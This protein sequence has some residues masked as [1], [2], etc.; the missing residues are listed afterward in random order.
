MTIIVYSKK[1]V[2]SQ[3][4]IEYI[5]KHFLNINYCNNICLEQINEIEKM[6]LLIEELVDEYIIIAD[7]NNGEKCFS[8]SILVKG[9]VIL[10]AESDESMIENEKQNNILVC[11]S[12]FKLDSFLMNLLKEE[13]FNHTL[14]NLTSREKEILKLIAKGLLNKEIA[15]ELNITERTVKNHI[16]NIFKKINVYDRTQAAV[17]AIKNKIFSL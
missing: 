12:L 3:L 4:L 6:T 10:I 15:N 5:E 16:S 13:S 9:K 8:D 11:T 7:Y 2:I 1:R 14:E 17:F